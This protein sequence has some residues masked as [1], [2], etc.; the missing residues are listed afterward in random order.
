MEQKAKTRHIYFGLTKTEKNQLNRCIELVHHETGKQFSLTRDQHDSL[1]LY[2]CS[3]L[4]LMEE[5]R[6]L[7]SPADQVAR[8]KKWRKQILPLISGKDAVAYPLIQ[9]QIRLA[10]KALA[11]Q[12]HLI[13]GIGHFQNVRPYD[14]VD[15]N[16]VPK[17]SIIQSQAASLAK[18][19][20]RR[21]SET[22]PI[23]SLLHTFN[24]VLGA[25]AGKK[26]FLA[27]FYRDVCHPLLFPQSKGRELGSLAE[28][29]L[30]YVTP[31]IRAKNKSK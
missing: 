13:A 21:D 6:Q 9:G 17:I 12:R 27:I 1:S 2:F 31:H 24:G 29:Y 10:Y 20:K 22:R 5:K 4:H 8:I 30:D 26:D 18:G 3:A 11:R 25:K 16:G 7:G 23:H 19:K 28:I 14:A 15:K